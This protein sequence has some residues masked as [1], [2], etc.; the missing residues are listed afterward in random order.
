MLEEVERKK[1]EMAKVTKELAEK[2]QNIVQSVLV[3]LAVVVL[4]IFRLR[5]RALTFKF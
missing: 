3:P 5:I 1:E 4:G 2:V